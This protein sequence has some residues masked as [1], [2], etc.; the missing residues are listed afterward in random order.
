MP[1]KK[2]RGPTRPEFSS[3][4]PKSPGL[5]APTTCVESV[6]GVNLREAMRASAF[7]PAD[8]PTLVQDI[9]AALQFTHDEGILHRDIKPENVLIDARGWVKIVD[10]GIAKLLG[11]DERDDFTLTMRGAALGSPLY[12]APE[13]TET[14]EEVDQRADLLSS[15][16]GDRGGV[17]TSLRALSVNNPLE[18]QLNQQEGD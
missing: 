3:D 5:L 1:L 2:E 12:M 8:T 14:P 17:T 4:R 15:H 13:Q 11:S 9:C 16:N 6:D 10:F 18:E 7:T